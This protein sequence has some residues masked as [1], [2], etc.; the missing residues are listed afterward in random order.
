MHVVH[1]ITPSGIGASIPAF[2]A[3]VQHND[4][5]SW[6]VILLVQACIVLCRV[7]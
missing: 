7:F 5:A 6:Q 3:G 4:V 1:T 2:I